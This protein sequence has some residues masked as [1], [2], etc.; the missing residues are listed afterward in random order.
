MMESNDFDGAMRQKERVRAP[1]RRQVQENEDEESSVPVGGAKKSGW[2]DMDTPAEGAAAAPPRGRRRQVEEEEV[3]ESKISHNPKHDQD[4]DDES[5]AMMIPDLDEEQAEDIT[6]QVAEA[7]SLK[8]SR[9]QTLKELD[10]EIDRALPPASEIGVDL[11]ALMRFLTP[12]EQVQEDDVPWDYGQELQMLAS[13]MTK[14]EEALALPG[15]DDKLD[16]RSMRT[17]LANL[18]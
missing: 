5:P 10:Q 18:D 3:T 14:E 4:S 16:A 8:S 9:V 11:S 17:R 6:R 1:R 12:Q 2:G 15:L 13:Q 7:P